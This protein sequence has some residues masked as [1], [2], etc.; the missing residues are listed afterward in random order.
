[1]KALFEECCKIH[2]ELL[3]FANG[4]SLYLGEIMMISENLKVPR[5]GLPALHCLNE[6][7]PFLRHKSNEFTVR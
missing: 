6:H 5:F 2:D 4:T 3:G 1:M 7:D